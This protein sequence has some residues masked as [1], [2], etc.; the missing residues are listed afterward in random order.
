MHRH[1]LSFLA[2]V[3]LYSQT[4]AMARSDWVEDD[5]IN[6]SNRSQ[7]RQPRPADSNGLEGEMQGDG[8]EEANSGGSP[9]M[10]SSGGQPLK[11]GV[12]EWRKTLRMSPGYSFSAEA[13]RQSI[14]ERAQILPPPKERAVSAGIFKNW[15]Q[16]SNPQF[17]SALATSIKKDQIFEV[18][19]SWDDSG[20]ILRSLGIPYTR[21][22]AD[23]LAKTPLPKMR[24]LVIDC[25]ANLSLEAQ[26]FVNKFVSEGG[27]LL[28]TDWALDAC[29]RPCFP[30]YVAWNGGYTR[31]EVVDAVAVGQDQS[32]F[33]SIDSPA[34]WKLEEKSQL[35]QVINPAVDILVCS[36]QLLREDPSQTGILALTFPFGKGQVLHLVGHFDNNPS[37]AFTNSLPDPSPNIV[38]SLRQAV[39]T[40]FIAG[41][42]AKTDTND[43]AVANDGSGN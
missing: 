25:G 40:N 20:H 27:F 32:L 33:K 34:Y 12:S 43:Q 42:F 31:S 35:V 2:V 41:A 15:L 21:I 19:G 16:K 4:A 24:V 13:A 22:G 14:L 6:G 9:P 5:T 18:K 8:S 10:H 38:V 7:L 29:L 39:A 30:G 23:T 17:A 3:C 1:L 26:R 11:G 36:R 28:T 37:G